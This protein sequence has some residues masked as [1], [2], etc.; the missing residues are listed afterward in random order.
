MYS[1]M[2]TSKLSF[3]S[4][5]RRKRAHDMDRRSVRGFS[6]I[7]VMVVVVIIGM[8]AGA[9][10]I[11]VGGY[12]DTARINRARSDIATIKDAVETYYAMHGT[13]P[14]NSDGLDALTNLENTN[15][16]WGKMYQY[17]SPGQEGPYEVFTLGADG[18]EGGEEAEAD[19]Y[20][21]DLETRNE[22]R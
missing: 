15:D 7:E 3:V 11:K 2:Q 21:W 10:A 22:G 9:V 1:K 8:L 20:S 14:S 4:N 16:P 13:Y 12:M 6:L 19:I 5:G 17:N 18:R